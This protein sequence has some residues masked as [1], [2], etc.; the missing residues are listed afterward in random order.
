ME[1]KAVP[2]DFFR[3]EVLQNTETKLVLIQGNLKGL[4]HLR[5]LLDRLINTNVVGGHSHLEEG[6][7]LTKSDVPVIIQQVD[8]DSNH[9][10]PH[11]ISIYP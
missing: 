1:S 7:G 3:L 2:E 11:R 8:D 10:G 9:D 6:H 5:N 4:T